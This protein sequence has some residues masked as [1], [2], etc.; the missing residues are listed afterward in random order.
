MSNIRVTYSGLISLGIGLVSVLTGIIFTLIVTRQLTPEEFGT[1]N[2]I[3]SLI[4]YVIIAEPI[5]SY[6]A[7]RQVARGIESGRTAVFS[8]GIFSIIGSFIYILIVLLVSEQTN[9]DKDILLFSIILIPLMFV[10]RTLIA[11]N[12]GWKP[13]ATSYGILGFEISKVPV[14]LLLVYFLDIGIQ[15]AIISTA[16]GYIISSIIL[17][18]FAKEKLKESFKIDF[19]KKWIKLSWITMYPAIGAFVFSLD[20]L[21]FSLLTGS[22][23][24]LAYYSAALAIASL[25]GHSGMISQALYAKLLEG[26]N[27]DHLRENFVRFFYF[28]FPLSAVSIVFAQP[29]LYALNPIYTIA[30]PVVI[31]MSIRG[32]IYQINGIF[33]QSLQGIEEVDIG[34]N[35]TF[36]DFLKS[37]LF[38]LPTLRIIRFASYTG[39]LTIVLLILLSQNLEQIDLII[40]WA[41]V[42]LVIEIP[43]L[44]YLFV[45]ARKHFTLNLPAKPIFKYAIS[46]TLVF[47]LISYLMENFL[48][49]EN[50]IFKFLPNVMVFLAIGGIMYLG[51]TYLIDEKTKLLFNSILAEIRKLV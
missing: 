8:S 7:T 48:K 38:F 27:R 11:I 19:L 15:G 50:E 17:L 40:Y 6:W 12:L 21:V 36:Q 46:T 4:L 26:G 35:S 28:G 49:Y 3:G 51:I 14:A 2:L 47:L 29:A 25:I 34:E 1:W 5:I 42:A 32:F 23:I 9:A 31:I 24:G 45:I 13:Q 20:V 39:L 43:F 10:N 33:D 37:K 30:V 22:V 16:F 44:I 41:M 18:Y